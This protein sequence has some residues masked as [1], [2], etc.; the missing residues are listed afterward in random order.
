M[1]FTFR[2]R[3]PL[4]AIFASLI[5]VALCFIALNYFQPAQIVPCTDAWADHLIL[6][7][8]LTLVLQIFI[9]QRV[10]P[11]RYKFFLL[12]HIIAVLFALWFGL[13]SISPLG[14]STGRIS[15]LRGFKV[16]TGN[17]TSIIADKGTLS[18]PQGRPV[19]I[20][21]LMLAGN[22]DCHWVSA[23]GG[24]LDLPS[25]CD[26]VY[27]PPTADYDILR[28]RVRSSCGVPSSSGQIKVGI[29]P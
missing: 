29:L 5:L 28:I 24:E 23:N 7:L 8:T 14:Y 11:R 26:I 25:T 1:I 15:N 18:L 19:G 21:P 27:V 3:S 16:I 13:Y 22:F 10:L 9:S 6:A 4:F 17:Q 20:S 12:I 2:N